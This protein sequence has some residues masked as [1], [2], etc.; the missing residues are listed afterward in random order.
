M[1]EEWTIDNFYIYIYIKDGNERLAQGED[2]VRT[3]LKKYF[4]DLYNVDTQEH[5]AIHICSFDEIL[6][7]N[8]FG[9]EPI[10]RAEVEVRDGKFKNWKA[11]GKD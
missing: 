5:V 9:G 6:R 11:A 2:E 8:Y 10:W 4:E 3:I 7:G 1:L